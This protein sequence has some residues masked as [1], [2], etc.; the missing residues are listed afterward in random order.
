MIAVSSVLMT[1]VTLAADNDEPATLSIIGSVQNSGSGC[2]VELNTNTMKLGNQDINALPE[3]GIHNNTS[4][5]QTN[6]ARLTGDNC[7]ESG[8]ALKFIGTADDQEGTAFTN[9]T[10]GSAAAQGI[11]VSVYNMG[12]TVI[13]P[14]TSTVLVLDKQYLFKVGM[15]KLK[16]ST[17]A[18]GLVQSSI[19]VQV[20]RL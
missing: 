14:N 3:Q 10:T 15:V 20:E 16:N 7:T 1:G 13:S 18:P 2:T 5:A 6:V 8:L 19:T 12:D 9:T 17:A 4:T 11:G